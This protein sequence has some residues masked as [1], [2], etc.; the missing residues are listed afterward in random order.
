MTQ[1]LQDQQDWPFTE[2][3]RSWVMGTPVGPRLVC[4]SQEASKTLMAILTRRDCEL[5]GLGGSLVTGIFKR[6]LSDSNMREPLGLPIS[7]LLSISDY[8][9]SKSG[10]LFFCNA[11]EMKDS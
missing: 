10:C 11:V 1:E 2:N 3:C 4:S 5:N 7:I 9:Q 6:S 8:L